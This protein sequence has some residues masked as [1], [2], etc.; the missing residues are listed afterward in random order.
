MQKSESLHRKD[1][2][3]Q[4]HEEQEGQKLIGGGRSSDFIGGQ[5]DRRHRFE[6]EKVMDQDQNNIMSSP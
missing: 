1:V 6:E 2:G 5:V 3:K 4:R